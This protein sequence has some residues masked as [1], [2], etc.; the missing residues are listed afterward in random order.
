MQDGHALGGAAHAIAHIRGS[1]FGQQR[2]VLA[3]HVQALGARRLALAQQVLV[4][5]QGLDQ[6][7][8]H[9]VL[10]LVGQLGL[11]ANASGLQL[12]VGKAC[13]LEYVQ[14]RSGVR[15][16]ALIHAVQNGTA[17]GRQLHIAAGGQ[18]RRTGPASRRH[19][20]HIAQRFGQG[21]AART[22]GGQAAMAHYIAVHRDPDRAGTGVE[23]DTLA[24]D[25]RGQH[26]R[27]FYAIDRGDGHIAR[28][29]HQPIDIGGGDDLADLQAAVAGQRIVV[30]VL[31]LID[32]H[33]AAGTDVELAD[34]VLDGDDHIAVGLDVGQG[35][36]DDHIA[37]HF[38]RI[39]RQGHGGERSVCVVWRRHRTDADAAAQ[40][41][42]AGG[43][44]GHRG[45]G[46][47]DQGLHR[48]RPIGLDAV[49]VEVFQPGDR[50]HLGGDDL[51]A[52]PATARFGR[53]VDGDFLVGKITLVGVVGF[54]GSPVHQ[55]ARGISHLDRRVAGGLDDAARQ[56]IGRVGHGL[57]AGELL[58]PFPQRSVAEVDDRERHLATDAHIGVELVG[59]DVAHQRLVLDQID[60]LVALLH[61]LSE[62][63]GVKA[64]A[65]DV[66]HVG[67]AEHQLGLEQRRTVG[68]AGVGEF[69]GGVG[70]QAIPVP[71]QQVEAALLVNIERGLGLGLAFGPDVIAPGLGVVAQAA[72]QIG[73][74]A[75]GATVAG[76]NNAARAI[77]NA[78]PGQRALEFLLAEVAVLEGEDLPLER[79]AVGYGDLAD[80]VFRGVDHARSQ[81]VLALVVDVDGGVAA[82]H[83]DRAVAGAD[84]GAGQVDDTAR[85]LDV[86]EHDGAG[87]GI[88]EAVHCG[89]TCRAVTD[90][91]ERVAQAVGEVARTRRCKVLV[92]RQLDV[93]H[94]A[95]QRAVDVQITRIDIDRT[96]R[97]DHGLFHHLV[98]SG[99]DLV[100]AGRV[101][102]ETHNRAD[103]H[104]IV[105][106]LV[107]GKGELLV[108]PGL[109]ALQHIAAAVE[110]R[111]RVVRE[112]VLRGWGKQQADGARRSQLDQVVVK[113]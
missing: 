39:G 81:G 83:L 44:Y 45:L 12:C 63:G 10:G 2:D 112:V 56:R 113:V 13:G 23:L 29:D 102:G 37:A 71:A 79:G 11:A 78:G 87:V 105:T 27:V 68:E 46:C 58:R 20:H 42:L 28:M 32:H 110:Q 107:H 52:Q 43:E 97:K 60:G 26:R 61:V 6:I 74:L 98:K 86:I 5:Q 49:G 22:L 25:A 48:N 93:V 80:A 41:Q 84:D 21:D 76:V 88:E 3:L 54:V 89:Q 36:A 35:P 9:H 101:E 4:R 62:H 95:L 65:K 18:H 55:I 57:T 17:L 108:A 91:L 7:G 38:Q 106:R 47:A 103:P 111:K 24:H 34:R 40:Q 66:G 72:R 77:G 31:Q 99:S 67:S 33:V 92:N 96:H 14:G 15:N 50:G 100:V 1:A 85:R 53:A 70:Y 75:A 90:A 51:F 64:R 94:T 19:Q 59:L 109:Y 30:A 69:G 8:G 73:H 16:S 104:K 82:R